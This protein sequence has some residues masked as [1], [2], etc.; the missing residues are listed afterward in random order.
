M[1]Q[2]FIILSAN[3]NY[4]IFFGN[5]NALDILIPNE[6]FEMCGANPKYTYSRDF[7][8]NFQHAWFIFDL[9]GGIS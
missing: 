6:E 3:L 9:S 7:P 2:S 4:N 1:Q 5:L 8:F